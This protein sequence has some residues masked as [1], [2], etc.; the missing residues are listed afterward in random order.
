MGLISSKRVFGDVY[1]DSKKP[2]V[3]ASAKE[4]FRRMSLV[5]DLLGLDNIERRSFHAIFDAMDGN[6]DVYVS[7]K[8]FMKFLNIENPQ[9]ASKMFELVVE[10][11]QD[12]HPVSSFHEKKKEP[13]ID[14][15]HFFIGIFHFSLR[16]GSAL[17]HDLFDCYSDK[18]QITL[19]KESNGHE[20]VAAMS[21]DS[22]EEMILDMKGEEYYM[23]VLE[24]VRM[25]YSQLDCPQ[26]TYDEFKDSDFEGPDFFEDIYD[27]AHSFRD[28]LQ[29]KTM[30]PIFAS[31]DHKR[32]KRKHKWKKWMKRKH[33]IIENLR[34]KEF[35]SVAACYFST[36]SDDVVPINLHEETHIKGVHG[37][38]QHKNPHN[39]GVQ[40]LDHVGHADTPVN[41][42]KN[43]KRGESRRT[44]H[45][46]ITETKLEKG[47]SNRG[48]F[49]HNFKK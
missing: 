6:G 1:D 3:V 13:T 27:E 2:N 48:V 5:M 21:Q 19:S 28:D 25:Y 18:K 47:R 42:H 36:G 49:F 29:E 16:S 11:T 22:F 26:I 34:E 38:D 44:L 35:S 45:K 40:D 43:L 30:L 33:Q 8:E 15:V 46:R 10:L 31:K 32:L 39:C 12:A 37:R 23:E 24:A 41:L 17:L 9:L 14:V 4:S 20:N 7:R